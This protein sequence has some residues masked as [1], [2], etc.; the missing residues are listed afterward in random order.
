L[1]YCVV[2]LHT[3]D[4]F[5]SHCRSIVLKHQSQHSGIAIPT[6]FCKQLLPDYE[7]GETHPSHPRFGSSSTKDE[8]SLDERKQGCKLHRSCWPWALGFQPCC[9]REGLTSATPWSSTMA[10][11]SQLASSPEEPYFDRRFPRYRGEDTSPT[12][13]REIWGWYAY[14]IA[15]EVFA[16]CGVGTYCRKIF[17]RL[18]LTLQARSSPSP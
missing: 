11:F 12:G 8:R 5:L 17:R 18:V 15:A 4:V 14:G 10:S 9:S 13:R 6:A 2:S 3:L 1:K 16:V 7:G